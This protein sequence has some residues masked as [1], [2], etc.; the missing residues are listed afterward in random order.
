MGISEVKKMAL[1]LIAEKA[2]IKERADEA[3]IDFRRPI[4]N[5]CSRNNPE[6]NKPFGVCMDCGCFLDLK[7]ASKINY[8]PKRLRSEITHCPNGFWNDKK[9]A[10]FYREMDGKELLK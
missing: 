5:G 1:H 8:N 10:N 7:V 6:E 4:C 3:T 9:I 2:I